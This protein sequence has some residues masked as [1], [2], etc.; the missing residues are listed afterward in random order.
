MLIGA[1]SSENIYAVKIN[2]EGAYGL[3]FPLNVY[4]RMSVSTASHEQIDHYERGFTTDSDGYAEIAL[5]DWSIHNGNGNQ[6]SVAMDGGNSQNYMD[7]YDA[8]PFIKG[9]V[10][11]FR[12]MDHS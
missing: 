4:L 3:S 11:E 5:P 8:F 9:E 6:F 10:F 2:I 12:L 7:F 1:G